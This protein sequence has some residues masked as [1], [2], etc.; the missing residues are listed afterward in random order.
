MTLPDLRPV[1]TNPDATNEGEH[2]GVDRGRD[3]DSAPPSERETRPRERALAR[4][5]SA[6]QPLAPTHSAL[7][8]TPT[9]SASPSVPEPAAWRPE[10]CAT[11]R[12]PWVA[13]ADSSFPDARFDAPLSPWSASVPRRVAHG[14]PQCAHRSEP[15]IARL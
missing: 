3:T 1:P 2:H 12:V 10:R 14:S 5:P 15:R 6:G 8:L 11:D 7:P 13:P 4:R 9:H